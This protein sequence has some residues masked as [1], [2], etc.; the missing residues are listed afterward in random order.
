MTHGLSKCILDGH[1][2]V[3]GQLHRIGSQRLQ[4]YHDARDDAAKKLITLGSF[5]EEEERR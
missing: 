1:Q 2:G 3:Y 5:P 4:N